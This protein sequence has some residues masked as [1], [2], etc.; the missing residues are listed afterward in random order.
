MAEW[1]PVSTAEKKCGAAKKYPTKKITGH[2]N[3]QS[4]SRRRRLLPPICK[5]TTHDARKTRPSTRSK[6]HKPA[7]RQALQVNTCAT[8]WKGIPGK[9]RRR[10]SANYKRTTLTARDATAAQRPPRNSAAGLENFRLFSRIQQRQREATEKTRGEI[11]PS[12]Q[13]A[14]EAPKGC[15]KLRFR[16]K[17]PQQKGARKTTRSH[18][19]NGATKRK[20][21]ETKKR[22]TYSSEGDP[23]SYNRKKN[24]KPQISQKKPKRPPTARTQTLTRQQALPPTPSAPIQRP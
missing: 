10:R 18:R 22:E 8:A 1:A 2:Q 15:K 4:R 11:R 19:I 9:N 3:A 20:R 24:K 7:N 13:A 16:G 6:T 12:N 14:T 17:F 21:R 5:K 23:Q